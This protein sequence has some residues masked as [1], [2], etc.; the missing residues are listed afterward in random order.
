MLKNFLITALRNLFREKGSSA[1]NLAGLTL[2][3]TCCLILFLLVKHLAS[4][5]NFHSKRDRIFRVVTEMDGNNSRFY[6]PGVPKPLPN[7]F[8]QDFPEAEEVTFTSYRSTA[9]IRVPQAGSEPK[10]FQE[11]AGVVFAQPNFFRTFDRAILSGDAFKGLDDPREA[12]IA[13][14]LARKY[15]DREDVIGE[16]VQYDSVEY[17]ITS[18]ME[19]PPGNTDLPFTLMLSYVTIE[20]ASEQSNWTSIWSDEHCYILLKEGAS[21]T[22]ITSRMRGFVEKYIGMDNFRHQMFKLQP[23]RDLHFDTRYSNYSYQT[24]PREILVAL[25]VVAA[26]LILTACINFINLSTA[27]AIKRSK[28]VGIRKSLGSS[29]AQLIAQFLGEATLVTVFAMLLSLGLTQIALGLVNAFLEL[30]LRLDFSGDPLLWVFVIKVTVLVSLLSGLYP[31]LVISGFRPVSALKN[32]ITNRSSSGYHLRRSLVVLQFFISQFFIMGTIVLLSQMNYFRSQDLGFR[33]DAVL[34]LPIP[35]R[36]F[37]GQADGASRMR[38]LRDQ[39]LGLAGV[40]H[41]SLSSTPPSSSSVNSTGFYFE[42]EGE[43]HRKDT[44][45]KQVDANYLPLYDIPLLAGENI[46]DED[47]ARNVLV[48]EEFVRVSGIRDP[49]AIIGKRIHFWGRTLPISGVVSNFHTVS[50]RDPL[51]PTVLMNRIEGYRT[52]SVRLNAANVT[53]MLEAIKAKWEAA[54]PEHLFDYQFLDE[55]IQEFYELEERLS[56]ILTVFTIMVVFIGCLGLFGLAT[57]MA[58]Q[59]TKEIGVRKALGAS[60]ESIIYLFSIEY[61]K[62][63]CIGF[64]IAAPAVWFLMNQWLATFAYKI[65]IGPVIFIAGFVLT[66]LIAL[67]TVGYK[68]FKAAV[69]NPI[70]SLR[71]E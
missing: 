36:E 56:V 43:D 63:I 51:E 25:A 2:G 64:V 61:V 26:F 14:S 49:Q 54:Y 34:I 66:L 39:I 21:P 33:K 67:L 20:R 71:Y 44:Q 1:L 55:S 22:E 38:T 53:P 31:S 65:T 69:V 58:N 16:I 7:A 48:N 9:L 57:F 47:T 37:P 50:L 11:E 19:D 35:E 13:R 32:Q 46:A 52:M 70:R 40:E 28:E 30:P 12:I 10:K 15:F 45:L 17:T 27:E 62:L 42:G 24:N 23:L 59:K 41:V 4:F 18:V 3:I 29:R 6:T 8:R 68:S 60:V 5:D